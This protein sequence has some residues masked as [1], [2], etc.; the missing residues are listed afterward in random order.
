MWNNVH[1]RSTS[2]DDTRHNSAD[3]KS[4][5][6]KGQKTEIR[7]RLQKKLTNQQAKIR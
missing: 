6:P 1:F 5:R 3:K 4:Q 7:E 2:H